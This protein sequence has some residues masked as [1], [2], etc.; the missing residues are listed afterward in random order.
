MTD[1]TRTPKDS[2]YARLRRQ[3][4][5]QKAATEGKP[6]HK[7]QRPAI[8]ASAVTEGTVRLYGLHTVRAAVENP[9]R[10][11]L[12]LRATRNGFVRLEIGEA[13]S[14]PFPVEIVEDTLY[15]VN[16]SVPSAVM[17]MEDGGF[18]GMAHPTSPWAAVA[19][20]EA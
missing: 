8:A 18:L 2:H 20:A 11:I 14:L 1:Q 6:P 9:A 3:H 7:A 15:P 13:E 19:A 17:R 12:R 10:K 4:R 16:F 5:D